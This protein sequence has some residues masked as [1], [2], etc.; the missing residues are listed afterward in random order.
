MKKYLSLVSIS[1]LA[2]LL[3][4]SFA[5]AQTTTPEPSANEY[6]Q[7]VQAIKQDLKTATDAAKADIEKARTAA[8]QKLDALKASLKNEKN[9]A[10]AQL[11]QMRLNGREEALTRFDNAV[12]RIS[13]LEDKVNLQITKIS[14]KNIDTTAAK[15]FV[16]TADTDLNNAKAKIT[17]ATTLLAGSTN[18][19]T[20][21]NKVK[22]QTLAKDTQTLIV[23]A[24][25]SLNDA[26]KSLKD[27]VKAQTIPVTTPT[28]STTNQ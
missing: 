6:G 9:K 28:T 3:S 10:T 18:Q 14:A 16:A 17:E 4:T 12:A 20:K 23:Q 24:R 21:E 26:V 5:F 19:L 27:A 1:T 2:L 22:L 25:Q 8:Q 15:N 13:T 11:K 7:Q